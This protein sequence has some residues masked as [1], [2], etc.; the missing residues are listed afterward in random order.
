MT[1]P[2]PPKD[3]R[4]LEF[5]PITGQFDVI[6]KFNPDRIVTHYYN[7]DGETPK[8]YDEPLRHI[9]RISINVIDLTPARAYMVHL[10]D[11][12]MVK[13]KLEIAAQQADG[14]QRASFIRTGVFYRVGPTLYIQGG[15]QSDFTMESTPGFDISYVFDNNRV[16]FKVLNAFAVPTYWTGYIEI[17][18]VKV[19]EV[20]LEQM[21]DVDPMVVV[22]N[23]GNVVV[24]G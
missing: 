10:M 24:V 2:C 16:N 22:D 3:K 7:S 14:L 9:D 19:S 13:V 21:K 4:S 5:N 12:E 18:Y 15:W 20:R 11:G 8:A 17:D 23:N 1:A 6:N